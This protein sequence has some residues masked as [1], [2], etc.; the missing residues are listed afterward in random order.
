MDE[1]LGTIKLFAFSRDHYGW[2]VCDGRV[3]PV[4][5]YSALYSIIGNTYGGTT[6]LDFKLPDLRGCIPIGSGVPSRGMNSVILGQNGKIST[7]GTGTINTLGLTYMICVELG[8][9]PAFSF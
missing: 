7:H 5:L 9:Y 1:I 6:G 3:L 4:L 2:M 8:I